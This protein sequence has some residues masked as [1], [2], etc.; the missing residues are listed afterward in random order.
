MKYKTLRSLNRRLCVQSIKLLD[1][2][3]K[4]WEFLAPDTFSYGNQAMSFLYYFERKRPTCLK[5]IFEKRML[6]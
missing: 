4:N 3:T 2:V 5:S 6:I 1:H